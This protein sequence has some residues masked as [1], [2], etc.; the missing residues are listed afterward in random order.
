MQYIWYFAETSKSSNRRAFRQQAGDYNAVAKTSTEW[1][2]QKKYGTFNFVTVWLSQGVKKALLLR[3]DI[4]GRGRKEQKKKNLYLQ[5]F[6][7]CCANRAAEA[8]DGGMLFSLE[9][10]TKI[11]VATQRREGRCASQG[12]LLP[13][14]F[15]WQTARP[16]TR[17]LSQ[18]LLSSVRALAPTASSSAC[19]MPVW[20]PK[21]L[22]SPR[23]GPKGQWKGCQL[24][25][26]FTAKHQRSPNKQCSGLP[27]TANMQP[28]IS[29]HASHALDGCSWTAHKRG[30]HR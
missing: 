11:P 6:C 3:M 8:A 2:L 27:A 23:R 14:P 16:H 1:L 19:W 24:G 22:T 10:Q 4:P 18:Q 21:G 25:R 9:V 5:R 30:R 28:V 7:Y 13:P 15:I 17:V 26:H 20:L 12:T 29:C